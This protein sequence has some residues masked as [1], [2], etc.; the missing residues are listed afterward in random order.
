MRS[1]EGLDNFFK[2]VS[3]AFQSLEEHLDI[4]EN[5]ELELKRRAAK[6][7]YLKANFK[8]NYAFSGT[9]QNQFL[10]RT[11][12]SK[13]RANNN[14]AVLMFSGHDCLNCCHMVKKSLS[15]CKNGLLYEG[16]SKYL[17]TFAS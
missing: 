4:L 2:E 3:R 6:Q 5:N 7:L 15:S 17:V 1:I 10:K 9:S 13:R 8:V 11:Q 12:Q 14:G 16:L